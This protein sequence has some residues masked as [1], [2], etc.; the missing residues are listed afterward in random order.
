MTLANK[1][2]TVVIVPVYN[3]VSIW[4]NSLKKSANISLYLR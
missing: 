3:S 4:K 2:N 1:D